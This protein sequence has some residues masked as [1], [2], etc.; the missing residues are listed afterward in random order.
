MWLL[1]AV[2]AVGGAIG[3]V[4]FLASGED[5]PAEVAQ[6]AP[7]QVNE[8]SGDFAGSGTGTNGEAPLDTF[9]IP[10]DGDGPTGFGQ[11][12]G[13]DGAIRNFGA[14]E[15]ISGTLVSIDGTGITL[16]TS[17]GTVDV[18]I[19]A[20]TPVRLSKTVDTA[21]DSLLAGTELVALLTR[22]TDG[23]LTATSIIIGGFGGGRAGGGGVRIGGGQTG[24]GTEFNAVPGTI[25]SFSGGVLELDTA[26]GPATI[27]VPGETAVQLTIPFSGATGEFAIDEQMTVLG[28]RGDDG[29][30][31]PF[32]VTSGE[33]GFGGLFGGGGGRRRGDGQFGGA[34]GGE[35]FTFTGD[36]PV[37]IFDGNTGDFSAAP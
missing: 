32:T 11:F 1:V 30:Y 15:P 2:V 9:Q 18:E 16:T 31:T 28:Q 14:I 35:G 7:G 26:D 34:E 8:D 6:A 17:S 5:E 36:G 37:I 12:G 20:E 22:S 3:S 29:S 25:T 27:A 33:G 19:P 21:G 10:V 24:D 23:S 4:T 13:G